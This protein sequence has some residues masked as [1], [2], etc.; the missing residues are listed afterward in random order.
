[1]EITP[2]RFSFSFNW[3][4]RLV[5]HFYWLLYTNNEILDMV[6]FDTGGFKGAQRVNPL[7]TTKKE[8]FLIYT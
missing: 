2:I 3:L 5:I 7:K 4:K 8:I 6:S 1:M